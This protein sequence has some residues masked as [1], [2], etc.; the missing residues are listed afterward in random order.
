MVKQHVRLGAVE[1]QQPYAQHRTTVAEKCAPWV[2]AL[3]S[4][5]TE[6]LRGHTVLRT[7]EHRAGVHSPDCEKLKPNKKQVRRKPKQH[8]AVVGFMVVLSKYPL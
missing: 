5:R 8:R 7:G 1:L 6:Q 4:A 3:R 2:V